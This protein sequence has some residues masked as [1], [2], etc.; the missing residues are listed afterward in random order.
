MLN[1]DSGITMIEFA[2]MEPPNHEMNQMRVIMKIF[3][4]EPP[5]LNVP[6]HWSVLFLWVILFCGCVSSIH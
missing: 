1:I 3:K 6:S 5:T 4:S 2:Q